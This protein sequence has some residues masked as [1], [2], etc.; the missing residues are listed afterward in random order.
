TAAFLAAL[1][2][3]VDAQAALRGIESF[4]G[5]R[6]RLQL[7]GDFGGVRL[8]D[9]FAHH[10]TAIRRTIEGL[11][12][13]PGV[14]RVIAVFEPRSNSMKLGVWHAALVEALGLADL[15]WIHRPDG[16]QWDLD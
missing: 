16:L 5:V 1:H 14:Q 3:G 12:A 15:A 4:A 6:R 7:L 11:R 13:R 2:V 8:I 10:P 9:D